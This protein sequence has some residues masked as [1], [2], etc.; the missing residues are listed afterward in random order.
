MHARRAARL[1]VNLVTSEQRL[2]GSSHKANGWQHVYV[3]PHL[4]TD[5]DEV[6]EG[7]CALR[8]VEVAETVCRHMLALSR[9]DQHF[10]WRTNYMPGRTAR[11]DQSRP[12]RRNLYFAREQRSAAPDGVC[13]N[14]ANGL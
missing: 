8:P 13:E 11:A 2:F 10:A 4:R 6:L 12:T 14:G 5:R 1:T 7:G 9:A 3:A